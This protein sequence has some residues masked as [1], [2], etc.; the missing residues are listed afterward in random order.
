M[1]EINNLTKGKAEIE[2]YL[3]RQRRRKFK[4]LER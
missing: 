2:A 4:K 3:K 1:K